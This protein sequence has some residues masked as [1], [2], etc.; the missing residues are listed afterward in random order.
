MTPSYLATLLVVCGSL[1]LTPQLPFEQENG[2]PL[3]REEQPSVIAT[4]LKSGDLRE[5]ALGAHLTAEYKR[6]EFVPELLSLLT[7][8]PTDRRQWQP[9][10][11]AQYD[12]DQVVLDALIQM[13]AKVPPDKII[14]FFEQYSDAL[15]VLFSE[16]RKENSRTLLSILS[17]VEHPTY[18]LAI[19]NL[20]AEVRA[21]GFAAQ[22]LR[23]LQIQV[24][25][26]VRDDDLET[27]FVEDDLGGACADGWIGL[28]EGFPPTG[29]YE[30]QM[31]P[32]QDTVL[33]CNGPVPI[34]YRRSIVAPGR[35]I[36]VGDCLSD[37][38]KNRYRGEYLA[39]LL[40][41]PMDS[42][43]LRY[44]R[45]HYVRWNG[46]EKYKNDLAKF[47]D[48]EN[49]AFSHLVEHLTESNLIE[50][51]EANTLTLKI[52]VSKV[53]DLRKDR[54]IPLWLPTGTKYIGEQ[55]QN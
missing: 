53:V 50:R 46:T 12:L 32:D 54:S 35:Q 19:C 52:E 23:D 21:P 22:L 47:V 37:M 51:H 20:L 7:L 9:G 29:I 28:S 36:G 43:E 30:L 18:W 41:V 34:F 11:A 13:K 3:P 2:T 10:M 40:G 4:L 17:K 8:L 31:H 48:Q 6:L 39:L 14:P 1:L 38:N 16:H 5:Q 55:P 25:V 27:G 45:T 44:Q 42:M 33:L 49:E 26:C 24:R 15:I